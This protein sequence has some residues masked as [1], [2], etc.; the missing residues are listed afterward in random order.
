MAGS[1]SSVPKITAVTGEEN[2]ISEVMV[3]MKKVY[4]I[5]TTMSIIYAVIRESSVADCCRIQTYWLVVKRVSDMI[6]PF[7]Q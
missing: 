3:Y 1:I 4:T 7:L 2:C 5:I 6:V